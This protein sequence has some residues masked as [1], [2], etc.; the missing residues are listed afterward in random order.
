MT[1]LRA[2]SEGARQIG[3]T[4]VSITVSLIAAFIPI[5][6]MG[7]VVGRLLREFAVTMTFAIAISAV[8]SL[9][10]TPTICARFGKTSPRVSR[11]HRLMEPLL[12]RL[13]A[14]YARGLRWSLRHPYLMLV[15]MLATVAATVQM[16]ID[17][18]KGFFP[19][20]DTGLVMA[21]TEASPDISFEAMQALH[22][23][24]FDHGLEP[25]KSCDST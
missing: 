19:Q 14:A 20:D 21:M 18:P 11:L 10:V 2:A 13:T 24:V 1:P 4:V 23:L 7:G 16:Y 6:F 12:S 17:A 9:T 15:V 25:E 22:C 8:V 3:F 5:L